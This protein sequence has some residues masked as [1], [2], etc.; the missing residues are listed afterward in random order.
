MGK[1]GITRRRVVL[2]VAGVVTVVL[3]LGVPGVQA[4]DNPGG[5][6]VVAKQTD[7]DGDTTSFEFV[8]TRPNGQQKVFSLHDDE[9]RLTGALDPGTYS[10]GENVPDGW[11][12]T[13]ASCDD[14]SSPSSIEIEGSETVTCTFF[15]KKNPPP[16]TRIIVVKE[17][18]PDE[19]PTSFDFTFTRPN[20]NSFAFSLQDGQRRVTGGLTAGVYSVVESGEEGWTLTS[21]TCSDG[22]SPSAIDVS[23]GEEVTCTFFNTKNP[24]PPDTGTIVV[25]KQTIPDGDETEF[26][27]VFEDE[28]GFSLSDGEQETFDGLSPGTYS[29]DE[30]DLEGWTLVSATCSDGSSPGSIDLD[31]GE[32]VTCTF[33][34]SKDNRPNRGSSITVS[35][36]AS[37]TSLKEPGGPVNYSVTITNTSA[38]IDVFITDVDDDKFGD[39][40]DD[41]GSGCFDVPIRLHP[42]GSVNCQF[43]KQITGAGGTSHVNTVTANGVDED[44]DPVSG[45]DD[46]RV[47][48]IAKVIDLVIVKDATSPTPLDGTV[49]YTMTVTNKGPDT[50]TNVQLA[51][52]APA[53]ITYLSATTSQGTCVVTA[54]LVTCD[55]GTIAPG[56][57]VTINVTGRATQVGEHT[58]T[59]TVTGSGGGEANPADNVDS[60]TTVVPAP[61]T[62]PTPKPKPKP[63]PVCMTVTVL[64]KMLKA[65][66]K[67]DSITV[68]VTAGKKRAPGVVVLVTGKDIRKTART[69]RQGVA[70]IKV[71]VKSPG[72][73]RVTT[74][75]KESCGAKQIG[76]IGVFTPP[77]T[78]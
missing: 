68:R 34:N 12:L 65:D 47:D 31:A 30:D 40:D 66:G 22:S 41:G 25:E 58:N 64:P 37:P 35:K 33:V 74:V 54:S 27:F 77:V 71:N 10:V 9:E 48:I 36:S 15:N 8:L 7:P 67:A 42:G 70:V 26:D 39:L 69:N 17:T 24:P 19:D 44:G 73:L 1:L 51:D 29:V 43:T 2:A 78:G 14:G 38:D 23:E 18:D 28:E 56:Q 63:K 62:P 32:T 13:S 76:I 6:I 53:G 21:A 55:L 3:A 59:A 60:A 49:N 57:V 46:A 4:T 61:I 16:A 5:K 75:S 20:G 52:P 50:A 45:S 72:L 11:T